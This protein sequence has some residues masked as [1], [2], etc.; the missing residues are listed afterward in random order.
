M[1]SHR[2]FENRNH[3][4]TTP[5]VQSFTLLKCFPEAQIQTEAESKGDLLVGPTR[6]A[7]G[8]LASLIPLL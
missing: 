8:T 5:C 4:S 2:P 1:K 7:F 3:F 6:V